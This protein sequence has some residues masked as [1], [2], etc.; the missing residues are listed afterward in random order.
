MGKIIAITNQKGGVGKSATSINLSA[1]LAHFG[2]R[3][4]LIDMDPQGNSSRGLGIDISL[5]ETSIFDVLK[6]DV[7]VNKAVQQTPMVGMDIIPSKMILAS[8][9]SLVEK[10]RSPLTL[11][12]RALKQ[13][14]TDYDFI[15]ID[16]PPSSSFLTENCLV[17]ANS[18]LIPIQCEPFALFATNQILSKIIN[19][20]ANLNPELEIEGFLLTMYDPKVNLSDEIM[21][22]VKKLFKENTFATPIPRTVSIP[23]SNMRGLPVCLFRPTSSA[24]TAF[25][26]LAREILDKNN[27]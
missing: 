8:I 9:D 15:I 27:Q 7:D 24:T 20:Q 10:S 3:V 2:K 22:E 1:S 11:L 18:I 23:E 17:A 4:L 21:E 5:V 12:K 25:F 19:I 13:L 26:S 6:R 16:C 14:K